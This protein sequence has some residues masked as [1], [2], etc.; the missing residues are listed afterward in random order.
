[1]KI[2]ITGPSGNMGIEVLRQIIELEQIEF[3]RLLLRKSKKNIKFAKNLSKQYKNKIQIVYGLIYDEE[4][5]KQL[6]KDIDYVIHMAGLIPPKTEKFPEESYKINVLGTKTLVDAIMNENPN[7]KFMHTSTVAV[8]GYRNELHPFGRVGDPLISGVFDAYSRDKIIA[9]RYILDKEMPNFVIFRQ[10]AMLS[11]KILMNNI[12]DGLMFHTALNTPLEWV[13]DRDTGYLFKRII[14]R[15]SNDEVPS[16]WRN[17]YNIGSNEI[18]RRTG[19]DTF[20]DGFKIINGSTEKFFKPNYFASRNFH[21]IWFYDSHVL[22]DYFNF[23]RDDVFSYWKEL[24]KANKLFSLGRFVPKSLLNLFLFNKL[25]K[26]ENS[27]MTW[28][29]ENNIPKVIAFFNGIDSY[30]NIPKD[31]KNVKLISKGDFGDPDEMKKVENAK[32]LNHGY[33]ESKKLED[34]TIEELKEAA[35]FRGGDCLEESFDRNIYK[36]IKWVCH[37]GHKFEASVFTILRGGQ[38]CPECCNQSVWNYDQISKYAPFFGQVWYD[39]HD[40]DENNIYI[41]DEKGN[42]FIKKYED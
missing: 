2:A 29:K 14:E 19:Y 35:R 24:K 12:S 15:D 9:E 6:V 5:C 34:L 23:Q 10:S 38:W 40:K 7:I 16:F 26:D 17:I 39:S 42:C 13:S 41:M 28:V 20:N 11:P 32:L 37:E 31:W 22:N 21:G 30:N 1:M 3:I 33:D 18:S 27:P 8:Y 25:L 4:A 36:K